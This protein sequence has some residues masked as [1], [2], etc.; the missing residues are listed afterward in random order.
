[1]QNSPDRSGM[2]VEALATQNLAT[3]IRTDSGTFQYDEVL[4]PSLLAKKRIGL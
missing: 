3:R 4:N 2:R 1:M